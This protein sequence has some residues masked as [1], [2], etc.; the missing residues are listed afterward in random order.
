[1]PQL[2]TGAQPTMTSS[3]PL[4]A[5]VE[6]YFSDD[7]QGGQGVSIE[8]FTPEPSPGKANVRTKRSNP[9]DMGPDRTPT[10]RVP[11][12][13][14]GKSDSGYSSQSVA[15]MSSADSAASAASSQRSPPV[16]PA[17]P[18]PTPTQKPSRPSHS[19]R[20]STQSAQSAQSASRHPLSRRDS[21]TAPR[22]DSQSSRR[23]PAERRPTL[24]T[25]TQ[26]PP[27][28]KRRD[29]RNV[30]PECTVPGCNCGSEPSEPKQ[31]LQARR[32]SMLRNQ[33]PAESAP[34]LSYQHVFDTRSQVSDPAQYQA[35][36][37]RESRPPR[38]HTPQG[39]PVVQPAVSRR[40]SVSGRQPRPTSYHGDPSYLWPQQPGM[41]ASHPNAPPEHGPPPSRSAFNS[42]PYGQ[43]PMNPQYMPPFPQPGPAPA[44][45][46][47][48]QQ[49]QP[50]RDQQRP[51]LQV[52]GQTQ[53][54]AYAYP[55]QSPVVQVHRSGDRNMPSARYNVNPP[56]PA[57]RQ[58][59]RIGYRNQEEEE[60]ESESETESESE[61]EP[62]PRP[63]PSQRRPS[64]RHARTTPAPQMPEIRRPQTIIV[65]DQR[66]NRPRE[67]NQA[68]RPPPA[69]RTSMSRPPLVPSI[70]SQS[71]YDTPQAR[72]IVEGSRSS[73]REPQVYDRIVQDHRRAR[74]QEYTDLTRSKR[75]SRVYDSRPTGHDYERDLRDDEEEAEP[76]ARPLRRRRDTDTESRRRSHRPV[77]V[78]QVADAEDYINANRGERETLADQSYEVAR[79]RS[80]RNSVGPSEAESSRSR[81]SDNNGEIRL[82]IGNDAPVTLSLN[83]DMEGRVLQLVPLD[84]GSNELVIS[85]NNRGENT[86]RSERGSVWGERERRA[87]MP[88]SQ[89]RRDAEEL[90]ERSLHSNR[91]RQDEPRRLHRSRR[92]RRESEYRY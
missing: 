49:M 25:Q 24:T 29:S 80:K 38:Y 84:D 3:K 90:T 66:D 74:Q 8:P 70:K 43:S 23:P 79:I 19:R 6:D 51:P 5:T 92:E 46:Y 18:S 31:R 68:P 91:M 26:Q 75:S 58:Q 14:D 71:A 15:G 77:D 65:P 61:E 78:R 40:L 76:M 63:R 34:D 88:A 35:S 11:A 33:Q 59:P 82:R 53:N 16:L 56:P 10:G 54:P 4:Q 72:T 81:G 60:S 52:R 87:I 39:G 89:P 37:P 69:R 64:L 83:G 67:R 17:N 50:M 13:M 48:A 7:G 73:R 86:Y 20:E 21:T 2:T 30:E 57:Q 44:A 36:S 28:P 9:G 55:P 27:V 1:M 47:Q 12:N 85:G 32:Q 62:E 42:F 22:R 41:H 45:F